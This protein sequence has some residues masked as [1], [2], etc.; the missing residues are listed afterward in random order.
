M[1]IISREEIYQKL[2]ISEAKLETYLEFLGLPADY[3]FKETLVENIC[4]LHGL[5]ADGYGYDEIK[6]LILAAQNTGAE[7]SGADLFAKLSPL[8]NLKEL[9]S[10]YQEA[11][12]DLNTRCENIY[13]AM[14]ELQVENNQLKASNEELQAKLI[15]A[16]EIVEEQAQTE[17]EIKTPVDIAILMK[18]QESALKQEYQEEI[19]KLKAQVEELITEKEHEWMQR[20]SISS[21]I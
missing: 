14:Q 1:R 19:L 6:Y 7:K 13:A 10:S 11:F 9:V 4:T 8:A 5:L 12:I 2:A 16:H 17:P 21:L 15:E 18:K 20:R 3:A